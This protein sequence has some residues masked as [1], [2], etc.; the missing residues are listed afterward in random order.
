VL[1]TPGTAFAVELVDPAVAKKLGLSD[2]LQLVI[3]LGGNLA[4]VNAQRSALESLGGVREIDPVVWRRMRAI[5]DATEDD[6]DSPH[7][8]IVV[9]ISGLPQRVAQIWTD[10]RNTLAGIDGAL[11]H[12]TPSLGI[13]RCILPAGTPLLFLERLANASPGAMIVY[14]R[15]PSHMWASLSPSV[16]SDR[17]SQRLKRAFDPS[18]ILNPGI[19]GPAS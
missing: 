7:T 8:P 18:N 10:A 13:I 2:K 19:L 4:A 14:E 6:W 3:Q 11:M 12:A 16:V 15:L 9:R 1:S 17:I 5:D